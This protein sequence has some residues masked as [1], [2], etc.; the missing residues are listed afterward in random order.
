MSLHPDCLAQLK[1]RQ[2]PFD[3]VPSEDFLY[4]D[5]LLESL[6]E[7]ATRALLAPGAIVILA[8]VAGS[9][10]SVQLMR[11]LG[12]LADDFELIAFRARPEVPFEAIEVTIRDHLSAAGLNQPQGT[13]VDLLTRRG[14]AGRALVLAVDDVHLLGSE[15][16]RGLLRLRAEIL[17]AK[18]EGVRLILVGDQSL[19]RDR[20][21][22]PDPA[23]ENQVVRLNLRPFNLEQAGAYLRH[24]LRVAGIEDPE[25][26]LTS[27]D[28]AA[29][30]TSSKGIPA[31]LNANANAW[32]AR[33]CRSANG[34]RQAI[35]GKIGGLMGQ[36]N[37]A[38]A[39]APDQVQTGDQTGGEAASADPAGILE[40][41][42]DGEGGGSADPQLAD[43]LIREDAR[44]ETY[45]FEQ[46]LRH[47]RK[48]HLNQESGAQVQGKPEPPAPLTRVPYWNRGWF[49]PLIL[50]VVLVAILVPV[51]VRWPD[52]GSQRPA[53]SPQ[54]SV[55]TPG[56]GGV[57]EPAAA[58][59]RADLGSS[60][61]EPAGSV[62]PTPQNRATEDETPGVA[63]GSG[64]PLAAQREAAAA[65]PAP[66][67]PPEPGP[68]EA[69]EPEGVA[70]SGP[71]EVDQSWLRR[72]DP[73]R[74][75][76]QLVAA[77][78]LAAAQASVGRY[79]LTGI[80]Y[81]QTRSFVIA[82]FGSFP[83][84]AEARRVLPSLPTEVRRHGPWIR[85]IR[86][87]L[88]SQP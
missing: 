88:E 11:L 71:P 41:E 74:F 58:A 62:D 3:A 55:A 79:D 22:L 61:G 8:G 49:L 84:R 6:I 30:Q 83:N 60:S 40:F 29:L 14:R 75:T 10:R 81:I 34:L 32:L 19:S 24:R 78:D 15:V 12:A 69:G 50:V 87:V 57:A 73:D 18:G 80:H 20:L 70:E 44:P 65:D 2:A 16:I 46:V 54:P 23:D 63:T 27:G 66:Q 43:Y 17:E 53:E 51:A 47:V 39:A 9:G 76:I 21:P 48:H 59:A 86:S 26:F 7:T 38:S 4:T 37:A 72:Q 42:G 67:M 28:I 25:G 45:D 82:L 31:A 36:S 85:T 52:L 64:Q 13:L 1:L 77:G 68:T 35:S 56:S 33:R 5:P